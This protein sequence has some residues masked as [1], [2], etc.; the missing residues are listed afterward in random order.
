[1]G[2]HNLRKLMNSPKRKKKQTGQEKDSE[3]SEGGDVPRRPADSAEVCLKGGW[4]TQM[5]GKIIGV[6][7]SVLFHSIF[8]FKHTYCWSTLVRRS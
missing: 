6:D 1:M 4:A 2:I 8:G 5:K 3:R 7:I